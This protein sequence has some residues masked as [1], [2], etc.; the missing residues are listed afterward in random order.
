MADSYN[1]IRRWEYSCTHTHKQ[2]RMMNQSVLRQGTSPTHIY[3]SSLDCLVSVSGLI[4]ATTH[5]TPLALLAWNCFVCSH[6]PM[7]TLRTEGVSAL[8][9]GFF[10]A[11][12]RIGPW[13]IIVSSDPPSLCVC[14]YVWY[15]MPVHLV[16]SLTFD[17]QFFITYEKLKVV[18]W[19]MS[20]CHFCTIYSCTS[21]HRQYQYYGVAQIEII[22][23][24]VS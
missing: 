14:V 7:Q 3:S 11:Y 22:N 2:S 17:L 5:T 8:Y 6:H 4:A 1:D 12:L 15:C 19:A 21:E 10:P 13:N 9:R 16:F 23:L 20:T 18:F 24:F